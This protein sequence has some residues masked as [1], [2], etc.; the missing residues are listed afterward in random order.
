MNRRRLAVVAIVLFVIAAGWF[1][2]VGLPA[3]YTARREQVVAEAA[4]P[5]ASQ[6][7][8]R[9]ITATIYYVGEDGMA[10]VP[11]QKEVSF[12]AAVPDQVPR[13]STLPSGENAS[14]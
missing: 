4:K 2:F 6:A 3:W 14:P 13:A 1:L 10:L 9:K 12:S 7:A 8:I 11:V 5:A